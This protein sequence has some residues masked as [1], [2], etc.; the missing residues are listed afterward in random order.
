MSAIAFSEFR[1]NLVIHL[2]TCKSNSFQSFWKS[3]GHQNDTM[4]PN[5]TGGITISAFKTPLF[6]QQL[7]D[8]LRMGVASV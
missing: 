4:K 7:Q 1:N 8:I 5:T 3:L 2:I 6:V